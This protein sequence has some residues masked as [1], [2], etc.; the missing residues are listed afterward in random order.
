MLSG[1]LSVL[2]FASSEQGKEKRL[3]DW[4]ALSPSD[5]HD[6]CK[7]QYSGIYLDDASRIISKI[8]KKGG[9]VKSNDID[10]KWSADIDEMT[11]EK[12]DATFSV[13]LIQGSY[14]HFSFMVRWY[15]REAQK[16][17]V[18]VQ[19]QYSWGTD[20]SSEWKN[21]IDLVLK[22]V[23]DEID[24][25]LASIF[26]RAISSTTVP[27][28]WQP[29]PQISNVVTLSHSV[30]VP[31]QTHQPVVG[32]IQGGSSLRSAFSQSSSLSAVNVP[33]RA[34]ADINEIDVKK[35][36]IGLLQREGHLSEPISNIKSLRWVGEC[37]ND[38]TTP[39]IIE[40]KI[41]FS[42]YEYYSEYASLKDELL[43]RWEIGALPN[44]KTTTIA[45]E[46]TGKFQPSSG[47][48]IRFI[49]DELNRELL[50]AGGKPVQY[51]PVQAR[52]NSN[53]R[54]P[55]NPSIDWFR[56]LPENK[57]HSTKP[58]WPS[59]QD[60]NE[61]VQ[62]PETC[63]SDP[64]L[65]MGVVET[66]ILGLPKVATGAFASVYQLEANGISYAV[67]CFNSAMKDQEE[68]YKRTSRFICAD[69][70]PYTVNLYF[71][72]KGIMLKGQW[73]PIL[74]MEWVDGLSIYTYID[75]N[76]T[77][78]RVIEDLR[79]R[80][81]FMM[82]E[83]RRVGVAHSDLQH[84]N[85]IIRDGDF[86]LV[87]Y[88][89]MFVPELS[90]FLSNERGHPNYQ[91]PS[92]EGKH[93]GPYLDNFSAWII[94]S[95]L[96]CLL[97]DPQMWSKFAG[98]GESLMFKRNDFERPKQSA[99]FAYMLDHDDDEIRE[100][101]EFLLSLLQ[102][103]I[104]SIPYLSEPNL[105]EPG[106]SAS[107]VQNSEIERDDTAAASKSG[108]VGVSESSEG[109]NYNGLPDWMR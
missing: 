92:R 108:P 25:E 69:D 102:T 88:D 46:W 16:L 55:A 79:Y 20:P 91:H 27:S 95:S 28:A 12:I 54:T 62:N 21:F 65:Q 23:E 83:L 64:E 103:Q 40:T 3:A 57:Q 67:R 70:L 98:D 99:I 1:V 5:L 4:K 18:E 42:E 9:L 109:K 71:L 37:S 93:F 26:N 63:F 87:D 78:Q 29:A 51:N 17:V 75:Q 61:A 43:I 13:F 96:L 105:S 80:F 97:K 7:K 66:S 22:S 6:L 81:G 11:P 49:L 47:D 19:T 72:D 15:I 59:L 73:F 39:S 32:L 36:L 48:L 24:I 14:I 85:I 100:R 86:V 94:D 76:Y 30:P 10:C 90:G 74:K 34:Y 45:C 68:R 77:E 60:Y 2:T 50:I 33:I 56:D 35:T 84:G 58:F 44:L 107:S 53:V 82:G 101:G 89:G 8:C 106:D 38:A 52:V 104:E 31:A 41:A